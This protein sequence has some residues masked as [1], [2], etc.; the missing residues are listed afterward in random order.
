MANGYDQNWD[1]NSYNRIY[2]NQN[3]ERWPGQNDFWQNMDS[4]G[5]YRPPGSFFPSGI[6]SFYNQ[7]PV[8]PGQRNIHEGFGTANLSSSVKDV[9]PQ[10][11]T[12]IL[13]NVKNWAGNTFSPLL[14]LA[15]M[16]NPLNK[17]AANYN[18]ALA[19]QVEDLRAIDFLGPRT[20]GYKIRGGPLADKNLVSLFGTNDY[21]Q[22]LAKKAA[23]F[24]KR[25]DLDKGFS[26]KN[27]DE[28]IAEQEARALENKDRGTTYTGPST[29]AFDRSGPTQ[30]SIRR[31]RPDKSGRG[32]R[33]GFTDP[34]RGSYG[35]HRAEGGRVGYKRGRVVN[36]GGYQGEEFEDENIFEFMQDQGVPHSQMVEGKSPFDLRIDELMDEGMSWQEAYEIAKEEFGQIAEGES[37]R[38]IASLV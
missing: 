17:R 16:R 25:K 8:Y 10:E 15:A 7:R 19:G 36:P 24:Q 14:N 21:D 33:G 31:E 18:P 12:G 28:V 11:K 37:D 32:H 29:V 20:E 13:Q 4:S 35:P 26:Q 9:P 38:G 5:N 6:G 27:W 2:R 34:G 22:M 1:I 3:P 30:A 23:W